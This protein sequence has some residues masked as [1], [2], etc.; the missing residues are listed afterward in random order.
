MKLIEA[1]KTD[2]RFG[3]ELEPS[4]PRKQSGP[5]LEVYYK[6][7]NIGVLATRD[8]SILD[9]KILFQPRGMECVSRRVAG[10]VAG[11]DAGI[12]KLMILD[13]FGSATRNLPSVNS[14]SKQDM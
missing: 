5:S 3:V 13:W 6:V 8:V 4:L 7:I 1:K 9:T 11:G 2:L 10:W 14:T 12:S